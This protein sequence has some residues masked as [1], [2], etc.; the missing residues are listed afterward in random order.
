MG[1]S[2]A[3]L[4]TPMQ[5]AGGLFRSMSPISGVVI[6]VAGTVGVSP[7]AIV[8]RTAL[9]MAVGIVVMTTLSLIVG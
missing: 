3:T 7:A 1:G 6:S 4:V 5:F 8:K 9:P 2:V